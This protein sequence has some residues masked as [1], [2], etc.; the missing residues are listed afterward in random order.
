MQLI[1]KYNFLYIRIIY[2]YVYIRGEPID[3]HSIKTDSWGL[4]VYSYNTVHVDVLLYLLMLGI[5]PCHLCLLSLVFSLI[6][7][8]VFLVSCRRN[9]K[10]RRIKLHKPTLTT[11]GMQGWLQMACTLVKK[12]P[13]RYPYIYRNIKFKGQGKPKGQDSLHEVLVATEIATAVT[14][15]LKPLSP[16]QSST[17]VGVSPVWRAEKW[18]KSLEQLRSLHSLLDDGII[19]EQEFLEQKSS[20][21][22][23]LKKL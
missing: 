11:V 5:L 8:K 12:I 14:K 20:I 21:L 17:L 2:S 4:L 6:V 15:T 3:Q 13:P 10:A 22:D 9:T 16:L 23:M 18:T 19:S 1:T 7:K